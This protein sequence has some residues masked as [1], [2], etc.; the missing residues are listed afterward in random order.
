MHKPPEVEPAPY[1]MIGTSCAE[2]KI[3][4]KVNLNLDTWYQYGIESV[5]ITIFGE[6]FTFSK[7]QIKYL[8]MKASSYLGNIPNIP[9][10]F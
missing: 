9:G 2:P 5:K 3:P 10:D 4:V 7:Q 6:D 1:P 8:L